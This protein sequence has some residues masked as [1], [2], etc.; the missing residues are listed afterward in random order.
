MSAET[1]PALRVQGDKKAAPSLRAAARMR[2]GLMKALEAG[3]V[4]LID[5]GDAKIAWMVVR[6]DPT[7]QK[8]GV[9]LT[10][11][12]TGD[13]R[14]IAAGDAPS[15]GVTCGA[16]T[17]LEAAAKALRA[18]RDAAESA[19][20]K[21]DAAPPTLTLKRRPEGARDSQKEIRSRAAV[22]LLGG[23]W[24]RSAILS[25]EAP[26]RGPR[27]TAADALAAIADCGAP[28]EEGG[29]LPLHAAPLCW[30]IDGQDPVAAPNGLAGKR[31]SVDLH[32]LSV[33]EASVRSLDALVAEAGAT[34]VSA[35]AGAYATGLGALSA[36]ERADGAAVIDLGAGQTT[37]AIFRRGRMAFAD[38]LRGGSGRAAEDLMRA[39]DLGAEDAQRLKRHDATVDLAAAAARQGAAAGGPSALEVARVLR[40]RYAESLEL[41]RDRL[42]QGG[43]Y[44]APSRRVVLAGG[45]AE[46]AGLAALAQE[47]L[48]AKTRVARP[49][50]PPGAPPEFGGAAYSALI[51]MAAAIAADAEAPVAQAQAAAAKKD[52]GKPGALWGWLRS[53]W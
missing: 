36:E 9:D 51:G 40:A 17:D 28:R 39:F 5:V 50:P 19:L 10:L 7:L 26:A 48:G 12:P 25:G 53:T 11:R 47:I 4:A 20:K 29:R 52:A 23:G 2:A 38:A 3:P 16:V 37:L 44:A 34:L 35:V 8:D 31:V 13:L 45:A 6:R 1:A 15:A 46:T 32:V 21:G 49:A 41:A 42:A 33:A 18:A 27:I 30:R 43:F 24:P 14:A 22:A